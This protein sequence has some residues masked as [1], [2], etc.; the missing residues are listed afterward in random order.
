MPLSGLRPLPLKLPAAASVICPDA[1]RA[2]SR[3]ALVLST[4]LVDANPCTLKTQRRKSAAGVLPKKKDEDPRWRRDAKFQVWEIEVMLGAPLAVVPIDR[5]VFYCTMQLS[6]SR[7][8]EVCG[9]RVKDFDRAVRPL[10]RLYIVEQGDGEELKGDAAP[11]EVPVH[12]LLWELLE[13]W[14]DS[15]FA[16]IIGRPPSPDDYHSKKLEAGE[17]PA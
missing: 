5:K 6:G 7:V 9:L 2:A 15:G 10:P 17:V 4:T 1:S 3:S 16:A 8:G 14:L 12:P 13:V 11:R